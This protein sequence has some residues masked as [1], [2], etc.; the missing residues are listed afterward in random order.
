MKKKLTRRNFLKTVSLFG[1]LPSIT[2]GSMKALASSPQLDPENPQAKAL[3]Y[4]HESIIANENCANCRLYIGDASQDWGPC[5]IFPG[6]NVASAG[7]CK[8]WVAKG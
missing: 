2:I 5:A 4:N 3:E 7:W 6:Q 1:V 8:A